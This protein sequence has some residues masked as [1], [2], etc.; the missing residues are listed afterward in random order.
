[1]YYFQSFID[2]ATFMAILTSRAS[3]SP[4]MG[5]VRWFSLTGLRFEMYIPQAHDGVTSGHFS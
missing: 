4:L 5:P 3:A 2:T 1:M